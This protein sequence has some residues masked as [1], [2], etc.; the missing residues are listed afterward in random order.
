MA[1]LAR[2][3][4][5]PQFTT[6]INTNLT[7]ELPQNL[8]NSDLKLMKCTL[9]KNENISLHGNVIQFFLLQLGPPVFHYGF[10]L[11]CILE[12]DSLVPKETNIKNKTKLSMC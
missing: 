9:L 1:S 8:K 2:L 3:P 7:M 11:V 12:R 5:N 4:S 10:P 6:W